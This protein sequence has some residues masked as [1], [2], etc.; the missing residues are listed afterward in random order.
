MLKRQLRAMSHK[1]RGSGITI[2][3]DFIGNCNIITQNTNVLQSGPAADG[4]VPAYDG[5]LHPGMVFDSR[6]IEE[7][8]AL[9]ANAIADNTVWTDCDV[10]S[11]ATV[12]ANLGTRVHEHI[13]SIHKRLQSYQC[14][15][16]GQYLSRRC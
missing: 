4:A 15:L 6:T 10:W 14:K 11:D 2:D 3:I 13:A 1:G 12:L 9:Q 5:A 8:T 16:R 7:D